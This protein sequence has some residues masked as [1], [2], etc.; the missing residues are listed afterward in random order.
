MFVVFYI[1]NLNI[2]VFM[3]CPT[4]CCLY[5][6]LMDPLIVCMYVHVCTYVCMFGREHLIWRPYLWLNR[7]YHIHEICYRSP[8]QKLVQQVWVSWILANRQSHFTLRR[9]YLPIIS[10]F[11]GR[12]RLNLVQKNPILKHPQTMFLLQG[13]RQSFNLFIFRHTLNTALG[14]TLTQLSWL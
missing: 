14:T 2:C 10:A 12:F 9:K 4:S 13:G 11:L 6:T 5:D 3:T 8:L 7:M 1:A